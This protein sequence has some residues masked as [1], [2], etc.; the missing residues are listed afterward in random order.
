M[1]KRD[2]MHR[3][4]ANH[5][6]GLVDGYASACH[7]SHHTAENDVLRSLERIV[8]EMKGNRDRFRLGK[9]VRKLVNR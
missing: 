9:A 3:Q 4:L 6:D 8:C 2:K 5:I 1:N 7:I